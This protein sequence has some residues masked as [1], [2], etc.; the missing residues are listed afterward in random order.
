M[1]TKLLRRIQK[2]I[3]KE[4]RQ[5]DMDFYFSEY[6]SLGVKI[7]RCGTAACIAG[8]AICLADKKTPQQAD[9]SLRMSPARFRAQEHLGLTAEQCDRLFYQG[10][11]PAP[12]KENYG[13]AKN[14]THAARI[15]CLR[16]D[17]FIKT[18]GAE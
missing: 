9:E 12:F 2:Q 15:A 16:I 11:W 5:F 4:P 18:K 6:H 1:N 10:G 17:H 13:G 3:L 7:P 8:W 14:A